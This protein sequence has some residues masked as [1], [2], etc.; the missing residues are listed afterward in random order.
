MVVRAAGETDAST[1]HRMM[2]AKPNARLIE[3][4]DAGHDLHLDQPA[5]WRQALETFLAEQPA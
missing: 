3:I 1:Y 2:N 5:S 4:D